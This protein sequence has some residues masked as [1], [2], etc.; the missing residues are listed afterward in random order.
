M[1]DCPCRALNS[2]TK[3]AKELG[4]QILKVHGNRPSNAYHLDHIVPHSFFSYMTENEIR[5]CWHPE[6]LRWW[7]AVDN[8]KRKNVLTQCEVRNMTD[9]QIE[10]LRFSSFSHLHGWDDKT[11]D[12]VLSTS[13][14]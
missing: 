14:G 8:I 3:L 12:L 4:E 13:T 7:L 11:I 1:V 2:R 9:T 10:I 5:S 6:N